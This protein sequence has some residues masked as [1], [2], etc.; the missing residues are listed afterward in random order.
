MTDNKGMQ[1]SFPTFQVQVLGS[2][3]A[4]ARGGSVYLQCVS[5]AVVSGDGYIVPLIVIQRPLTFA[6]DQIGSVSKVKHVV[7]VSARTFTI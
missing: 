3:D 4:L 1:K 5:V 6:F 2:I 7:D